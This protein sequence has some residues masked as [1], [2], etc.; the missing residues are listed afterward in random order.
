MLVHDFDE[1]GDDDIIVGNFGLNS[2][3]K[4][5]RQQPL[6]LVYKDFDKN[7][8]VD[9]FLVYYVEGKPYPFASRDE[10]LDQMYSMRPRYTS[11]AS[12]ADAQLENL[13]S[14]EELKDAKTLRATTLET[15]YLENANGKLIRK[16][17]PGESQFSPAHA[18]ATV[19][20]NNDGNMDFV[21]AGNESSI[22]IRMGVIDANF[23]QLFQ[24]DGKGNFS[25]VPQE[26]SGLTTTGDVKS[27]RVID[28]K[29]GRFLLLGIN[30]VG[31]QSYRI[32]EKR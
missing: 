18:I 24:G 22:R 25:Y 30:N 13:F 23:G 6:S 26:K 32:N 10:L 19:D 11:Y 3:L 28:T 12:Y 9:P 20:F 14:K 8:S 1:D 15:I 27:L 29:G 2:Q 7:G 17:L 4:A 5:G 21:L 16:Q 31:V